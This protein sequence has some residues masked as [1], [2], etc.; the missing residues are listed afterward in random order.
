MTANTDITA[1]IAAQSDSR[2]AHHEAGHAVAVVHRGGELRS[3][4]LGKVDW[5]STG[6]D[7]DEPGETHHRGRYENEPFVT[8]AGPWAEAMWSADNDPDIDDIT[9]STRIRVDQQRRR[10]RRRRHSQVRKQNGRT[11]NRRQH[12]GIPKYRL[13]VAVGSPLV[14]RARGIMARDLRGSR[15]THRWRCYHASRRR[16]ASKSIAL[17]SSDARRHGQQRRASPEPAS[18]QPNGRESPMTTISDHP[19]N[20]AN[21]DTLDHAPSGTLH[22]LRIPHRNAR[23]PRRLHTIHA[24][25][26]SSHS[27]EYP[28]ANRKPSRQPARQR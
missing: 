16:S 22:P 27:R 26:K 10:R 28:A 18:R 13:I 7:A 3:V 1:A 9:R 15:V 17:D 19:R 23:A 5:S 24:A 14:R 12:K 8:F 20:R 25:T 4:R 11:R 2:H 21:S 6:L